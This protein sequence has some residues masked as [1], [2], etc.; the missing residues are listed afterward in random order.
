MP[1]VMR[2]DAA[3]FTPSRPLDIE[4]PGAHGLKP[5]LGATA[6]GYGDEQLSTAAPSP[7]LTF[8]SLGPTSPLLSP[9]RGPLGLPEAPGL[10]RLVLPDAEDGSVTPPDTEFVLTGLE[11]LRKSVASLLGLPTASSA[12]S[13]ASSLSPAGGRHTHDAAAGGPPPPPPGLELSMKGPGSAT[14][15]TPPRTPPLLALP[16]GLEVP[17]QPD[18][19]LAAE[20]ATASPAAAKAL[21]P[22]GTTTAMLRNIPNKYTQEALLERLRSGGYGRS[23]DFVYVPIDF[24]NRC[25]FGYAFLNFRTEEACACFAEEFHGAESRTKLPG[26][27]SRKVCE[28]S[29]ARHQGLE[30]NV[31]RLRDSAVMAELVSLGKPEW[32]P[33]IFGED[34]EAVDFPLPPAATTLRG[35]AVAVA[36]AAKSGE[37]A[38]AA[39][40]ALAKK[41]NR[42]GG[43]GGDGAS[44]RSRGGRSGG[45]AGAKA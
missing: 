15:G 40:P 33:K 39:P 6:G 37:K 10:E 44:Q 5:S 41:K 28:V 34:G 17:Q 31:R 30:E 3:A 8:A 21:L 38:E 18:V 7:A 13:T 9:V 22:A 43:R 14:T 36:V 12:T 35:P 16:P 2:A 29:P 1:A 32:M 24:K 11:D 42:S 26:F 23:L 4:K 27:Q 25:N 19:K 20:V 45:G